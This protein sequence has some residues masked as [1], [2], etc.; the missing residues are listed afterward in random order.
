MDKPEASDELYIDMGYLAGSLAG[1]WWRQRMLPSNLR[2]VHESEVERLENQITLIKGNPRLRTDVEA[3]NL[4]LKAKLE[5]FA[6]FRDELK[7]SASL[8]DRAIAGSMTAI[9]ADNKGMGNE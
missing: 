8:P 9:L 4:R 6:R 1:T 3:E 5:R 2:F 7:A